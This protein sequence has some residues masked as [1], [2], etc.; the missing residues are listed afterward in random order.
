MLF[1][2]CAIFSTLIR[3]TFAYVNYGTYVVAPGWK[4]PR[5]LLNSRRLTRHLIEIPCKFTNC[6]HHSLQKGENNN[7]SQSEAVMSVAMWLVSKHSVHFFS[8]T[9]FSYLIYELPTID[10]DRGLCVCLTVGQSS[11]VHGLSNMDVNMHR[12]WQQ[13]CTNPIPRNCW[14]SINSR[15][16]L[17]MIDG[18]NAHRSV[19]DEPV[20]EWANC[21]QAVRYLTRCHWNYCGTTRVTHRSSRLK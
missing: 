17:I 15:C 4:G 14:R 8:K 16:S 10:G 5:Y 3:G 20:S 1:Q 12:T 21:L 2:E 9:T 11:S 19:I 18:M 6:H 13:G 7:R